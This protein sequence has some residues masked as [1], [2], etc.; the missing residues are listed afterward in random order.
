MSKTIYK[1]GRGFTLIEIIVVMLI[2]GISAG[3]VA[4]LVGKSSANRDLKV[5][6]KDASAMLRY[7][8]NHAIAE[9]RKYSFVV[10]GNAGSYG[11]YT[12][13]TPNADIEDAVP[14]VKRPVSEMLNVQSEKHSSEVVIEFFP[15]GNSSGGVVKVTTPKQK[16]VYIAVNRVTGRVEILKDLN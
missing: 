13:L 6:V 14:I 10:S 7:A 9:K 1:S 12:D 15:Q 5:F 4:V 16:S 2:V 8:R 11:L 3:L